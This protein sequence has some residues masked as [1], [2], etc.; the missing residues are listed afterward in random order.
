MAVLFVAVRLVACKKNVGG[1]QTV[2]VATALG[3]LLATVVTTTESRPT[4]VNLTLAIF[5][6]KFVARAIAA[7]FLSH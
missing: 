3:T 6:T 7:A 5:K 4:S 2:S 1:S